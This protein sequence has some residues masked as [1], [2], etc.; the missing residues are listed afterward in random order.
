MEENR[1]R[2]E[3]LMKTAVTVAATRFAL[4]SLGYCSLEAYLSGHAALTAGLA[5]SSAVAAIWIDRQV[6]AAH[7]R[8]ATFGSVAGIGAANFV[9]ALIR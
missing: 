2:N 7:D 1:K 8:A 5:M 6:I 9:M 3:L 4:V